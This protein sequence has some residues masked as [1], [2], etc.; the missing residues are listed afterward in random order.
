MPLYIY[1]CKECQ[2]E[3]IERCPRIEDRDRQYCGKGHKL[4]RKLAFTGVVYSN[5][6]NGGMK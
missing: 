3:H 6:A 5:T 4:E 2:Q 1:K